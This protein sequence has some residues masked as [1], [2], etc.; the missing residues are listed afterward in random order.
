[1]F[2]VK[3]GTMACSNA[4]HQPVLHMRSG[5]GD[6]TWLTC[7]GTPVGLLPGRDYEVEEIDLEPGDIIVFYTD[8]IAE[9]EDQEGEEFGPDRLADVVKKNR[10]GSA[11]NLVSIIHDAAERFRAPDPPKDDVTVI[12]VRIPKNEAQKNPRIE[13][14]VESM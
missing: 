1:V 10:N 2:D 4:G 9:A 12:V 13:Q 6:V 7:G 14:Y 8:G 5:K 3:R 11:E